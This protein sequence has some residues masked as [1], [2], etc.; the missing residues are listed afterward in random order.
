MMTELVFMMQTWMEFRSLR[1]P[2]VRGA[3]VKERELSCL[4]LL[5]FCL[6]DLVVYCV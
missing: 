6:V 3:L 2:M 1:V 4:F 5:C